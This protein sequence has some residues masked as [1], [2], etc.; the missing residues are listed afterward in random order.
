M[1]GEIIFGILAWI[2]GMVILTTVAAVIWIE[3]IG[4]RLDRTTRRCREYI[5]GRYEREN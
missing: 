2:G 5:E 4:R 1:I 3:V